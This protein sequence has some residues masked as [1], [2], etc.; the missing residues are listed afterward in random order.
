MAQTLGIYIHIP[1]CR[2]KCD[3][4]DFYSLAGCDDKMDDYH[5]A[6]LAH[7]RQASQ[8]LKQ[9]QIDS[10]YLGGG[11]PSYYGDAR[12]REILALIKKLCSVSKTAEI[13]MECNPDSVDAG[14]MVR[15]KKAGI[16]RISLGM[17][18]ANCR[19]LS[20]LHRPHSA[21]EVATAMVKIREAKIDN[22]SLDL[23]YGL[24]EQDLASWQETL[25]HAISLKPQHI[26]AY[27][28]KVEEKTALYQRVL[29]GEK[30]PDDDVQADMYLYLCKRLP[31]A[32]YR[33]Y[34]ISNFARTGKE[35]RH[36]LKYWMGREYLGFGPGAHSDFGGKRYSFS[37]NLDGYI[38]ASNASSELIDTSAEIDK[39]ERA[40]EYI[41]LRMRTARGI[42][43]WEY[44]R[45]FY[46]NFEPIQH[47]LDTFESRGWVK[48]DG[49]RWHF[50]PEG[51][52]LSNALLGELL[53]A[54]EKDM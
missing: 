37:R 22:I 31:K 5:A 8:K 47:K 35:S 25:E 46:L 26:S 34:E 33:Q 14:A 36:N 40:R 13:T 3:Y 30:L 16:N 11:T 42:E 17:Q 50:T 43:E 24:P 10:I 48:Q 28:L 38:S 54:A 44:R 7:I 52:L 1:F 4:C 6:L 12:I 21:E 45:E 20:L 27:G 23:I 18:T 51:C 53:E 19:E 15:L 9:H 29:Q 32:G 2:S 49:H 41:M 39:L